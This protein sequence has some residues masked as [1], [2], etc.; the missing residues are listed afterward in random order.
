MVK[1]RGVSASIANLKCL[2]PVRPNPTRRYQTVSDEG[3]ALISDRHL[4]K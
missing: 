3:I 2:M 4:M 1:M